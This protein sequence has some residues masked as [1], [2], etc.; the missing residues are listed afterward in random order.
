[1]ANLKDTEVD[2]VVEY[3]IVDKSGEKT[4]A[5]FLLAG[6]GHPERLGF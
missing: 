3:T 6:P 2:D 1:M 4:D 5:V